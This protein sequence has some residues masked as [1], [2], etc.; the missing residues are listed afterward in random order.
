MFTNRDDHSLAYYRNV[1]LAKM[2]D[3]SGLYT[4]YN[5]GFNKIIAKEYTLP[6]NQL[7]KEI[8]Y[9]PDMPTGRVVEEHSTAYSYYYNAT[10]ATRKTFK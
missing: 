10:V 1:R 2:Q 5:Y 9:Q 4:Q 7:Q 3:G 6:S 8:I